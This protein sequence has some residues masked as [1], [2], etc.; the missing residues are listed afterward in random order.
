MIQ[1]MD[2]ARTPLRQAKRSSTGGS[3]S[4]IQFVRRS[5]VKTIYKTEREGRKD[6][7]EGRKDGGGGGG[8]GDD[9]DD[10][11]EEDMTASST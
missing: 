9:D 1:N 8:G 6:Q 2:R 4:F 3:I 11:G 10:D 7:R 5:N